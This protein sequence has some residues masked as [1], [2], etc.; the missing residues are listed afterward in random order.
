MYTVLHKN[1]SF[2]I[3]GLDG[4]LFSY[5]YIDAFNGYTMKPPTHFNA[6]ADS[7][8]QIR[9]HLD[10]LGIPMLVYVA[11]NKARILSESIPESFVRKPD[12]P[13]PLSEFTRA[14]QSAGLEITDLNQLLLNAKAAGEPSAF[15]NTGIH[16][17][18]N[19]IATVLPTFDTQISAA[20]N[21]P[22]QG[23]HLNGGEWSNEP[24]LKADVDLSEKLNMIAV[25]DIQPQYVP[26]V[27]VSAAWE[28]K[29]KILWISDSYAWGLVGSKS[30]FLFSDSWEFWFYN[31]SV[32]TTSGSKSPIDR[33]L[34]PERIK[35]FDLVIFMGT[36][37]NLRRMPYGFLRDLQQ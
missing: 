13:T 3:K 1:T 19:G 36:E 20:L 17:N 10:S 35:E 25:P 15:C 11:P 12:N 4:Q 22:P 28:E 32:I 23:L 8:V 16:W 2:V 14:T 21:L 24:Y 37:S 26:N 9:H 5:E 30:L 6:I 33:S 34:T 18:Y 29:P 31:N 7:L 27:E